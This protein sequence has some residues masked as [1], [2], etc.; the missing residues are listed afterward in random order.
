MASNHPLQ[1]ASLPTVVEKPKIQLPP[2]RT[3]ELDHNP[4][5]CQRAI[6]ELQW[7][8][9]ELNRRFTMFWNEL[10]RARNRF[11]LANPAERLFPLRNPRTGLEIPRCPLTSEEIWSLSAPAAASFL[12]TMGAPVPDHLQAMRSA[13]WRQFF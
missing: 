9:E 7:Q 4:H 13:A 1:P 2:I 11:K 5:Q 6:A 3:L 12:Q 10:A 8:M